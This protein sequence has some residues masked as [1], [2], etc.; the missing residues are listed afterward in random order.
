MGSFFTFVQENWAVISANGWQHLW[1]VIQVLVIATVIG[2]LVAVLVYRSNTASGTVNALSAVG[3]TIPS[4]AMLGVLTGFIPNG[5]LLSVL[6]LV[7]YGM[8][9][10]MRNAVVGLQGVD[11]T[12]IESAKGMGMSR[13]TTL[14]RLEIPLAWP[15]IMTGV[16]VSGQMLMGIAAIAAYVQGPGL[17]NFIFSG[18]SR[19]GGANATESV[20]LGTVAIIL[21]AIVLDLALTLVKRVTTSKGIRV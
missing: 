8:L 6:A 21:L 15:V 2:V 20:V 5:V 14:R 16:R 7:F 9:P 3:L 17:G 18:I 11:Q 10:I 12:L 13:F 4:F 1:L 19:T